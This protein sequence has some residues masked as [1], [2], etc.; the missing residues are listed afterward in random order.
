MQRK[1]IEKLSLE[2]LFYKLLAFL[3]PDAFWEMA[4]KIP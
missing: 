4:L 3:K 1:K 2:R